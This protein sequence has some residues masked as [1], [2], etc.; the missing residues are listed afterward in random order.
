[1]KTITAHLKSEDHQLAVAAS[2]KCQPVISAAA[3]EAQRKR[4][5]AVAVAMK[6]VMWLANEEI[7]NVKFKSLMDFLRSLNVESANHLTVSGN[8]QYTS[9]QIHEDL[10]KAV[11]KVIRDQLKNELHQSPFIAI[12]LDES[13]DR[14]QEN[15]LAAVVR[16]VSLDGSLT[17]T[18]LTLHHIR[19]GTSQT[20]FS[21]LQ[22]ILEEFEIP[23]SK[24]I[25]LGTDGAAAM[26]STLHG[27][28][29]LMMEKNPHTICVHCVCHRLNLAVS[30]ACQ[31][32]PDMQV[33]Q[34][35]MSSV[36]GHV[37]RWPKAL[38]KF[39]DIAAILEQDVCRFQRLF[40]IRWLSFGDALCALIKNYEP[41]MIVLDDDAAEG[42][43]TAIGL[44]QQLSTYKF[45]ALLHLAADVF[46]IT[47]QLSKIMQYNEVNFSVLS[48]AV[49][50]YTEKN[51]RG[52]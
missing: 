31:N 12:G 29:G 41:L 25:D 30:Q 34:R 13:S 33:L 20:I 11:C 24:V 50:Y 37:Q 2:S 35:I 43:P 28:S 49:P 10:L 8:V 44:L 32:L 23:V 6:A 40:D 17:T 9:S 1:M 5:N 22:Q 14:S 48:T 47:N 16:Y 38:Q 52:Q 19:D 42:D 18:F 4:R 36:Y 15:H 45:V 21:T 3:Q 51:A 27:V 26:A 46:G 7:A 39:K